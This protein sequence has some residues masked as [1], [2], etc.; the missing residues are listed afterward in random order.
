MAMTAGFARL[1]GANGLEIPGCPEEILLP[2]AVR[3]VMD[4]PART[5]AW[6][7]DRPS[8]LAGRTD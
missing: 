8:S 7:L 6:R 4:V 2:D 1:R 3:N 5:G